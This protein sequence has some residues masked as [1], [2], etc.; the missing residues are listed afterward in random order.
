MGLLR[1]RQPLDRKRVFAL[2]RPLCHLIDDR[3]GRDEFLKE[4]Y[5]HVPVGANRCESREERR[6][7]VW[8][9]KEV[10][11]LPPRQRSAQAPEP[12][13]RPR[14]RL[15]LRRGSIDPID[16]QNTPAQRRAIREAGLRLPG[17]PKGLNVRSVAVVA[18]AL[19][20]Q[21]V[22]LDLGAVSGFV[23]PFGPVVQKH[24]RFHG[25]VGGE[26]GAAVLALG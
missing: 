25:H 13:E 11:A 9:R 1:D 5:R 19:G 3:K 26:P 10:Q 17:L 6:L 12:V 24:R 23:L 2:K 18:I 21:F 14:R 20:R 22:G 8:K 4:N 16:F 7:L 15:T